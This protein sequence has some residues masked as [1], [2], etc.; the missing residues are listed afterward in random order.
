MKAIF[1]LTFLF[2]PLFAASAAAAPVLFDIFPENGTYI[3]GTDTNIFL[4][5]V[6]DSAL[7]VSTVF[8]HVRVDDPTSTWSNISMAANCYNVSLAD[9]Y[10]N[11]TVPGLSALVSDGNV[12]L[13]YFDAYNANNEYG[14]NG[15]ASSPNRVVVDRS[16]P[17][18]NFTVPVNQSYVSGNVTIQ[19][20]IRDVFSGVDDSTANYSFDN[21]TWLPLSKQGSVYTAEQTWNTAAYGNNQTVA[22]YAKAADKLGNKNFVYINVTVDNEI[23]RLQIILPYL[24]QNI[25]GSFLVNISAEDSFAGLDNA[26]AALSIASAQ[27]SLACTGSLYSMNCSA[28]LNTTD[29]AD[30]SYNITFSIKDRAGNVVQNQTT[31]VIDNLP[32]QITIL[33]PQHQSEVKGTVT[34]RANIVDLGTGV[35]NASYRWEAG[36]ISSWILLTCSGSS[37]TP[38]CNGKWNTS[39]VSDGVY[40]I[41]LQAYDGLSRQGTAEIRVTVK[42]AAAQTQTQTTQ[43]TTTTAVAT[44]ETAAP[45][46]NKT[47]GTAEKPQPSIGDVLQRIGAFFQKVG[48]AIQKNWWIVVTIA[49]VI[50]LLAYLFW[51]VKPQTFKYSY[52]PASNS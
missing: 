27:Y 19:L 28:L 4:T 20:Q 25:S 24:N 39:E 13:Y 42:N 6:N 1:F 11:T 9:W 41:R 10:C 33:H 45:E 17:I 8:L 37:K 2:L 35:V 14:S 48:D 38:T 32:P 47:E 31:V 3:N 16:S 26:T 50:A 12:L 43:T 36:N 44:T 40:T 30:D 22:L 5:R 51:P 15:T 21:S 23:P 7:N 34:I 49:A 46:E 18:I 52:K 29:F